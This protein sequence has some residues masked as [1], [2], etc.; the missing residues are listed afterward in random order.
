MPFGFTVDVILAPKPETTTVGWATIV[1]A[2]H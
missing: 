1:G 2:G